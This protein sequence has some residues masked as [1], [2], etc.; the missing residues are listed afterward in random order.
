VTFRARYFII[1]ACSCLNG[2]FLPFLKINFQFSTNK[3]AKTIARERRQCGIKLARK[4][5]KRIVVRIVL[6][7]GMKHEKLEGLEVR[8]TENVS[9]K[10][11]V[12][13]RSTRFA[14]PRLPRLHLTEKMINS[15]GE[16]GALVSHQCFT[17]RDRFS[18]LS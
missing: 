6:C 14:I 17:E 10:L 15:R 7:R 5:A 8:S 2:F 18:R 13:H 11:E 4:K 9:A 3:R 16:C 12:S 1:T